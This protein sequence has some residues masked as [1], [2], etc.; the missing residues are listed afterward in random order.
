MQ[1]YEEVANNHMISRE[2]HLICHI[3]VKDLAGIAIPVIF[4]FRKSP[5]KDHKSN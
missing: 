2:Y 5:M 4:S 3:L 1:R